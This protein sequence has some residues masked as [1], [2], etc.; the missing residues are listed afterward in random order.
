MF[1]EYRIQVTA[2]VNRNMKIS[3]KPVLCVQRTTEYD[4]EKGTVYAGVETCT[5]RV[6]VCIS[7]LF[8]LKNPTAHTRKSRK[9]GHYLSLIL[10]HEKS[11][12]LQIIP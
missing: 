10:L 4:Y 5:F 12:L 7:S 8:S 6:T 2:I 3:S 9:P 1:T 11:L